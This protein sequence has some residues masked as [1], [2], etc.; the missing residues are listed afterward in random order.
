MMFIEVERRSVTAHVVASE[1]EWWVI[2]QG[3]LVCVNFH[4]SRNEGILVGRKHLSLCLEIRLSSYLIRYSGY[5]KEFEIL[6]LNRNTRFVCRSL[7]KG[8]SCNTGVHVSQPHQ[9]YSLRETRKW[10]KENERRS[11]VEVTWSGN[12]DHLWADWSR[13]SLY[14]LTLW[15]NCHVELGTMRDL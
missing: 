15:L 4:Y 6:I 14:S 5:D 13:K 10:K 11:S 3:A 7:E 12:F 9:R 2:E 1:Q 8:K